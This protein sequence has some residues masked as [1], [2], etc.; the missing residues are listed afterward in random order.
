MSETT[1]EATRPSLWFHSL[2][3]G[4]PR[5]S[6][7]SGSTLIAVISPILHCT[8]LARYDS[9][10]CQCDRAAVQ[11]DRH[12][13]GCDSFGKV[14]PSQRLWILW[15]AEKV[16][17]SPALLVCPSIQGATHATGGDHHDPRTH[18]G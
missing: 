5:A 12:T 10:P 13:T 1:A 2:L 6:S 8:P 9:S 15:E 11:S 3:F 4:L 16:W 18:C 14:L 17:P 7:R